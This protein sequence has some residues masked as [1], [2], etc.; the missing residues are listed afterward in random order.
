MQKIKIF[1]IV[2][3]SNLLISKTIRAQV[4]ISATG[5]NPHASAMLDV[6]ATNKGV[7]ITRVSLSSTTDVTTIASPATS[8]LV[9]NT[10]AS[11]TGGSVGYFYWN[12]TNWTKLNDGTAT[13]SGGLWNASGNNISN[14]NSGNVGI[15]TAAPTTPLHI[16]GQQAITLPNGG[17]ET[18]NITALINDNSPVSGSGSKVGLYTLVQNHDAA[19]VGILSEAVT[20]DNANNFGVLANLLGG[21][22]NGNLAYAVGAVD[23]TPPSTDPLSNRGALYISGNTRYTGVPNA[24]EA[25]TIITNAGNGTMQWSKPVAFKAY[26]TLLDT[27]GLISRPDR[28]IKYEY[29]AYNLSNGFNPSTSVFT[30]PEAGIYHFEYSIVLNNPDT[31]EASNMSIYLSQNNFFIVS[32]SNFYHQHR[33]ANVSV[34]QFYTYN[35]F[36]LKGS[37]DVQLNEGDRISVIGGKNNAGIAYVNPNYLDAVFSGFLIR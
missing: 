32:G 7:L 20:K 30:A 24:N 8:L 15:G 16:T 21:V 29:V 10:N 5:V 19:N 25:G 4:G 31:Q 28:Q 22:Q 14:A 18:S 17:T 11:M 26:K 13:S 1:L 23:V 34:S 12:G 33:S 3:L 9:F 6:S 37:V 36:T 27:I 2:A 35:Y